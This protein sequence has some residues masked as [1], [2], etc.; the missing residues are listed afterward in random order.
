MSI[1]LVFSKFSQIALVAARHGQ[2][3]ENYENARENL[4]LILLGLMRLHIQTA[5]LLI[6][7]IC[8]KKTHPL[9]LQLKRML[10]L[11]LLF[12]N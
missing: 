9:Q 10:L 8:V 2:I 7:I 4:S 1:S 12:F 5:C 6:N 3:C 11:L